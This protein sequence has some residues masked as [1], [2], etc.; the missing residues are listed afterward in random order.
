MESILGVNIQEELERSE[1]KYEK[2]L[3][4]KT[5]LSPLTWAV[6]TGMK[7]NCKV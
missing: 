7:Q 5:Y 1:K 4:G 6:E 2:C 3:R